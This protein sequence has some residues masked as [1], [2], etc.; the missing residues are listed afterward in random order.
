M[1]DVRKTT[2]ESHYDQTS[3]ATRRTSQTQSSNA[4][5][6]SSTSQTATGEQQQTQRQ[7]ANIGFNIA[8]KVTIRGGEP[9]DSPS[10]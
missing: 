6:S 10:C 7:F 4:R 3:D 8:F 2:T 9:T 1:S 5:A